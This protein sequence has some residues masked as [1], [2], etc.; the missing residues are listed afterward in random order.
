MIT[1]III[2]YVADVSFKPINKEWYK[3]LIEANKNADGFIDKTELPAISGD[4]NHS[5]VLRFKDLKSAEMWLVNPI[6]KKLLANA[7]IEKVEGIKSVIHENSEF[8]FADNKTIKK[9]KQV[10]ISFISVYPLTQVLPNIINRIFNIFNI[11][12]FLFKGIL[13]SLCISI[14]MVY[15]LMPLVIGILKNWIYTKQ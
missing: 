9:W 1:T 11:E 7:K 2:Q 5:L 3:L 8:W 10:I 4:H 15:V 12:Y 14:L 6:R 13:V